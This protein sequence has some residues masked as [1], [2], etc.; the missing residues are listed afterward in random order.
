M[1]W[2]HNYG[3]GH[4]ALKRSKLPLTKMVTSTFKCE[5]SLSTYDKI[6]DSIVSENKIRPL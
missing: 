3:E 4:I 1:G 2:I 5:Q 6:Y